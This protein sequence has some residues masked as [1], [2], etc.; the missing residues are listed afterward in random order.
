[1]IAIPYILIF[2]LLSHVDL[3]SPFKPNSAPGC[4]WRR[5]CRRRH[6]AIASRRP[7]RPPRCR[8]AQR[9]SR[10]WSRSRSRRGPTK[11]HPA[12]RPTSSGLGVEIV[13]YYIWYTVIYHVLS[14]YIIILIWYIYIYYVLLSYKV[15]LSCAI[16]YYAIYL[17]DPVIISRSQG[18]FRALFSSSH[19]KLRP[20]W[21][22]T[23]T[24]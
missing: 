21:I 9:R 6:P 19:F 8:W 17:H 22:K 23:G 11:W 15:T 13:S 4:W 12:G 14:Y 10:S 24:R 1:M 5:R 3:S 16:I 2:H 7:R 18:P 20:I